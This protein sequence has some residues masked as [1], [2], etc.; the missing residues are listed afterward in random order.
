MPVVV[1]ELGN[2][3]DKQREGVSFE[4]SDNIQE[5]FILKEAHSSVSYLEMRASDA[6]HD[7]LKEFRDNIV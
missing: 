5:E 1:G 2:N 4:I 7:S 6:F 3:R